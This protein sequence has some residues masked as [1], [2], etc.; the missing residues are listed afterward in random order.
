[1]FALFFIVVV[2]V[3]GISSWVI[4]FGILWG[5]TQYIQSQFILSFVRALLTEGR[6]KVSEM[7]VGDINLLSPLY[8][9]IVGGGVL[10][11][12]TPTILSGSSGFPI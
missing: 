6:E 12:S 5:H 1:M 9:Y 11:S 8:T 10:A 2:F 7:F 4:L 3:L